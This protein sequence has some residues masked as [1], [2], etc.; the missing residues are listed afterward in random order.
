MPNMTGPELVEL[1]RDAEPTLPV[2]YMSGYSQEVLGTDDRDDGVPLLEKP[3]DE[4]GILHSVH[5]AIA[6]AGRPRQHETVGEG[7]L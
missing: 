7:D 5:E 2:L 4:A 6:A 3:F 1:V